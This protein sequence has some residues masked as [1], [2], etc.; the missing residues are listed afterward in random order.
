MV[1]FSRV[2]RFWVGGLFLVLLGGGPL[3]AEDVYFAEAGNYQSK[4]TYPGDFETSELYWS[5]DG[6]APYR[7]SRAP[8]LLA[9]L[10][11]SPAKAA[12]IDR[13]YWVGTL[14]DAGNCGPEGDPKVWVSGNFVNYLGTLP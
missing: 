2:V 3:F 8:R 11:C 6:K 7:L 12:L 14:D 9:Q 5:Y 1:V 10:H 13:G 4:Q